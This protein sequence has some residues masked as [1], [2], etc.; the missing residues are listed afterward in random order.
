LRRFVEAVITEVRVEGRHLD[1]LESLLR[2][3]RVAWLRE[4][5]PGKMHQDKSAT[6]L[7]R[8]TFTMVEW[9]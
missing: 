1:V 6:V 9:H 4:L 2:N 7:T 3:H 5:P 8:F